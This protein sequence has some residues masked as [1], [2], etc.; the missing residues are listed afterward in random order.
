MNGRCAFCGEPFSVIH[1]AL[2][3]QVEKF[4]Y[5]SHAIRTVS[6]LEQT[7]Y[8]R[9]KG[10]MK[11]AL[12]RQLLR[13]SEKEEEM[14]RRVTWDRD[15]ER[16][17][18]AKNNRNRLKQAV[19]AKDFSKFV[20]RTRKG[21]DEAHTPPFACEVFFDRV[22]YEEFTRNSKQRRTFLQRLR[23][24]VAAMLNILDEQVGS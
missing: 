22:E 11:V 7:C 12:K 6:D 24:D 3:C 9:H 21:A 5:H 17:K 4:W 2:Q 19:M 20:K 1:K 13:E 16:Q 18:A 8:E 15:H 14:F 10:P 23:E